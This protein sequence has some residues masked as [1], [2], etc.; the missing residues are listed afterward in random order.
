MDSVERIRCIIRNIEAPVR[1]ARL[2]NELKAEIRNNKKYENIYKGKRCFVLGNGPSLN[3]CRLEILTDEKVFCVNE[4]VRHSKID[5]VKPDFYIVADPVFF[6]LDENN[7]E[8]NEL[9]RKFKSLAVINPEL[10]FFVPATCKSMVERYGWSDVLKMNYFQTGY[11]MSDDYKRKIDFSRI[12]PSVQAVIQHA[13]LLAI[14]MGF[15]EIYMLGTEQTNIFGNLK[16]YLND[17][18]ISDYSFSLNESERRWKNKKLTQ[19][20]LQTTLRGYARIFEIYDQIELLCERL[21]VKI[22]NCAKET[23]IQKIP[24]ME[25]DSLFGQ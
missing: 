8:E 20:S 15:S 11:Y 5:I 24:K 16:A 1:F 9:V 23:M 7:P 13:I 12:V 14:Y 21:G 17:V 4:F 3:S 18:D 10:Q 2:P 6:K 19:D 25:F 22:Y